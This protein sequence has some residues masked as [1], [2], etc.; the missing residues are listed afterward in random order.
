M[1]PDDLTLEQLRERSGLSIDEEG[2]LLHRGQP[3]TH[4]RTLA[5]L[6]GSLQRG[7][8]GRYAVT[9]GRERAY[10]AIADAPYAVRAVTPDPA[11]GAPALSLSD[12]SA[13]PLDPATLSLGVDG[14]LRCTVKG[15][16]RARF[17]RAGQVA[18]GALLQEDPPGSAHFQLDVN[19][20]RWPIG[21][22]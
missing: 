3:I 19:G 8:D 15:G 18:M 7:P 12:G 6:W 11:G 14:V 16:H 1:A 9:V 17:T 22:A 10:V 2:R 21:R 13:E 4:A 5:V 20:R